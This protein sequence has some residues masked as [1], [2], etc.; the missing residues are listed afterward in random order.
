MELKIY[1]KY[2]SF[3]KAYP[4]NFSYYN[5]SNYMCGDISKQTLRVSLNLSS[6]ILFCLTHTSNI[7]IDHNTETDEEKLIG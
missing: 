5:Y 3:I 2:S 4:Y 6:F 7:R 1:T